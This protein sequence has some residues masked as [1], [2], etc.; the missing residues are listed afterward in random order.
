MLYY[1]LH[2]ITLSAIVI[3]TVRVRNPWGNEAEWEGAWSD[4]S[5]EWKLVSEDERKEIGLS[6]DDDGEFW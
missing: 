2:S 6:F 5:P 3:I 1:L 4:S